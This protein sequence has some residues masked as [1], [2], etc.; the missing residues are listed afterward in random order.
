MV[1]AFA[2]LDLWLSSI[3]IM[4]DDRIYSGIPFY[5]VTVCVETEYSMDA[6]QQSL[7]QTHFYAVTARPPVEEILLLGWRD[8][9]SP[10]SSSDINASTQ[11]QSGRRMFS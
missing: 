5:C 8:F 11:S 10:L 4:I 6:T 9:W 3:M 2:V 1:R 7:L